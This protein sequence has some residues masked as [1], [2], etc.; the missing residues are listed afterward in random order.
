LN[1]QLLSN[2]HTDWK[3]EEW[4]NAP[5]IIP[6]NEVKDAINVR[7]TI[8]YA[9]LTSWDVNWYECEGKHR[10]QVISKPELKDYLMDIH[11]GMTGQHLGKI[12][13]VLGMP[14][15]IN[16]NFDIE[17]GIINGCVGSL[18]SVCYTLKA[19]GARHAISC[20]VSTPSTS[21]E[22]LPHLMTHETAVLWDT[23]DMSFINPFSR[24]KCQIKHTQLPISPGFAMTTHK[25]QGQTLL[26][27]II[28]LEG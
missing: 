28:D 26:R 19:N 22:P 7:A 5:V 27:T 25:A 4:L 18:Q 12:P 23:V 6:T 8:A 21:G 9:K 16:Q 24:K 17:A 11:L 13:L 20:I 14:I 3:A 15:I 10:G 2:V 1:L